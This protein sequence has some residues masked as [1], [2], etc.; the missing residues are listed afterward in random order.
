M[1]NSYLVLVTDNVQL[2]PN[3]QLNGKLAN[4]A[5]SFVEIGDVENQ[6]DLYENG[7]VDIQN[8]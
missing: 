6:E 5:F 7:L 8:T 3:N 4:I 1:G 2:I